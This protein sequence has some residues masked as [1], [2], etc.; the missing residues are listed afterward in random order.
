VLNGAT[1]AEVDEAL[2]N[3]GYNSRTL[4]GTL[5]EAVRAAHEIARPGDVVL[6]APGYTSFDQFA[7]FEQRGDAFAA[8][9][10]DVCGAARGTA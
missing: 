6:L 9:V 7:D 10:R 2:A 3:L 1:G 5:G 4:V 8:L